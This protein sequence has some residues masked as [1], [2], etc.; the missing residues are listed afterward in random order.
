MVRTSVQILKH[1]NSKTNVSETTTTRHNLQ[2]GDDGRSI[3]ERKGGGSLH[4]LLQQLVPKEQEQ[5][6]KL[7]KWGLIKQC[8]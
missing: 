6:R 1:V 2:P 3:P 8:D 7:R 5:E 4:R